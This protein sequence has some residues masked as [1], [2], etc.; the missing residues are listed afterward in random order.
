MKTVADAKAL[1]SAKA[2]EDAAEK[3]E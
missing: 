2:E 1:A 3:S